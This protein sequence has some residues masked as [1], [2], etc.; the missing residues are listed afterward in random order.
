MWFSKKINKPVVADNPKQS[1]LEYFIYLEREYSWY[2]RAAKIHNVIWI[3]AQGTVIVSSLLTALVA[4]L[5]HE[6][7]FKS[8][9]WLRIS[10]IVLP[11]LGTF[12]SSVLLQTRVRDL[13]NLRDKGRQNVRTI[14]DN[15]KVEFAAATTEVKY[16]II[17]R[18]LIE[19]MDKLDQEQTTGFFNFAPDIKP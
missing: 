15:G 16:T 18:D 5:A 4:A 1:L 13:L 17:H 3:V 6:Q 14:I 7:T 19:K 2:E 12:S 8:Y 11:L 9:D 10:L